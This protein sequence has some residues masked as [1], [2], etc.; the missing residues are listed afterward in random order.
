M[1]KAGVYFFPSLSVK[2]RRQEEC[3]SKT[4]QK[5]GEMRNEHSLLTITGFI[6]ESSMVAIGD[7]CHREDNSCSSGKVIR[8]TER[9]S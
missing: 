3:V 6:V 7:L 9:Q 5:S 1:R 4:L 8:Q 2:D